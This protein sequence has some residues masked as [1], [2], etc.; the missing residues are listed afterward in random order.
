MFMN[1]RLRYGT[2]DPKMASNIA[3]MVK[4]QPFWETDMPALNTGKTPLGIKIRA[5]ELIH[6]VDDMEREPR[7]TTREMGEIVRERL[8]IAYPN[9][10]PRTVPKA[11]T[12]ASKYVSKARK[13]RGE[14]DMPWSIGVST[15][16]QIPGD[17][18]GDLMD[19]WKRHLLSGRRWF[20]IRQAKWAST[21]RGIIPDESENRIEKLSMW[22]D[23]YTWRELAC[24][25]LDE[26]NVTA[27]LDARLAFD[28][29]KDIYDA[30]VATDGVPKLTTIDYAK[31]L[32][33]DVPVARLIAGLGVSHNWL[34]QHPLILDGHENG[35]QGGPISVW[36]IWRDAIS[37]N[38]PEDIQRSPDA[39][40]LDLAEQVLAYFEAKSDSEQSE[41]FMPSKELL[42][43]VGFA[44]WR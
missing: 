39:I 43:E 29:S 19:I 40:S 42:D 24:H 25:V 10:A 26:P 38:W 8:E 20:T 3:K 11:R 16:Y 33:W 36:H 22:A 21:V 9:A 4:P 5:Y 44:G 30:L 1:H 31:K 15:E 7:L 34:T 35:G 37:R 41:S 12:I 23:I 17:A 6:E 32:R 13:V 27:D 28:D 18:A 14:Q 2:M